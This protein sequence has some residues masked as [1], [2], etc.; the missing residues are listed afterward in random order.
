M[1]VKTI[2]DGF[3]YTK[4]A[5]Y[6]TGQVDV[7]TSQTGFQTSRTNL[8]TGQTGWK[9]SQTNLKSR[10]MNFLRILGLK[11]NLLVSGYF[12]GNEVKYYLKMN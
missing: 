12:I 3:Q 6:D 2:L 10:R 11:L 5:G 7:E 8:E 1:G 4:R 9:T